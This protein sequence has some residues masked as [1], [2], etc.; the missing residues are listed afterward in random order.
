MNRKLFSVQEV[1]QFGQSV[2]DDIKKT[3]GK[4]YDEATEAGLKC[5]SI[6]SM[7]PYYTFKRE[8]DDKSYRWSRSNKQWGVKEK[9][10]HPK[11]VKFDKGNVKSLLGGSK[12]FSPGSDYS[13]HSDHEGA[14][15]VL[16]VQKKDG[17]WIDP[18]Y[19]KTREQGKET[20]ESWKNRS[21]E[22]YKA[23]IVEKDKMKEYKE[24]HSE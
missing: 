8:D 2:K 19:L 10:Q 3:M 9:G 14:K 20:L 22:G 12:T 1:R 11:E 24:K 15:F 17:G 16:L 13:V 7:A 4:A 23:E 5:G 18:L 21:K 6:N